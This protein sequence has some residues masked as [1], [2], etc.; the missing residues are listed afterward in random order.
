MSYKDVNSNVVTIPQTC[1]SSGT[2]NSILKVKLNSNGYSP[3]SQLYNL[4]FYGFDISSNVPNK[5]INFSIR[6]YSE[7]YIVEYDSNIISSSNQP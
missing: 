4:S 3:D 1:V 5:T 6:D 2:D 7:N